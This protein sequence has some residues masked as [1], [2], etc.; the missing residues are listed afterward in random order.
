MGKEEIQKQINQYHGERA[1]KAA[2]DWFDHVESV[3]EQQLEYVRSKKKGFEQTLVSKAGRVKPNEV[4]DWTID[5][6]QQI[7][8]K[9]DNAARAIGFL[10][11]REC[12]N[13]MKIEGENK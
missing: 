2:R 11:V 5:S 12:L 10:A 1:V 9:F 6:L 3:L 13:D 4:V 7:N 8:F